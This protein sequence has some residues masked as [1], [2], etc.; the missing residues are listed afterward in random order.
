MRE[1]RERGTLRGS[2]ISV[3]QP[4]YHF[5]HLYT[6]N[7][8]YILSLTAIALGLQVSAQNLNFYAYT[9]GTD[10]SYENIRLRN[11]ASPYG[12]MAENNMTR[13]LRAEVGDSDYAVTISCDGNIDVWQPEDTLYIEVGCYVRAFSLFDGYGPWNDTSYNLGF[14]VCQDCDTQVIGN[15]FELIPNCN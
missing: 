3:L 14:T 2:P 11:N 6:T 8:K 9:N 15:D 10:V 4:T 7:M 5:T 13:S 1:R 12:E